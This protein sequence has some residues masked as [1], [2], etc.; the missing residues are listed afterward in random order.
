VT[1][2][3]AVPLPAAGGNRPDREF[4]WRGAMYWAP[5]LGLALGASAA[6]LLYVLGHLLR[7]DELLGAVLTLGWLAVLTRGFHLDGL[8]DLADGLGSRRPAGAALDVMKRSDLGPIGAVTLIFVL[9]IQ[10]AALTG[11]QVDGRACSALLTAG[12]T[13]RLALTWICRRGVP[14]AR[15][16]GLGARVAGIVHPRL[17]A[18]LT[19]VAAAFVLPLGGIFLIA[20]LAGLASGEL[21]SR[22][23]IRRLGGITG[24]VLG[25]AAEVAFTTCLVVTALR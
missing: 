8:A 4:D 14:S 20:L 17:A 18:A 5:L 1:L 19:I 15:T 6:G 24:D 22:L 12:L 7:A 21:T 13:S 10:V 2:L 25:A 11:A 23:A 16:E 9:L 3:T